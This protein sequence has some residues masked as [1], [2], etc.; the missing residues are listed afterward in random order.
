MELSNTFTVDLPV[1]DAWQALTGLAPTGTLAMVVGPVPARFHGIAR[2]DERD[3]RAHRA[4]IRAQGEDVGGQGAAMATVTAS[5]SE[6]GRGTKV[7]VRTDLRLSGRLAEVGSGVVAAVT[8]RQLGEFVRQV[9]A[10]FVRAPAELPDREPVLAEPI[11]KRVLP[12]VVAVLALVAAVLLGRT[13]RKVI[14]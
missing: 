12:A 1:A 11:V 5:L 9:E 13:V 6:F 7:E 4:V 14:E 2:I 8:S 10:G 3:D